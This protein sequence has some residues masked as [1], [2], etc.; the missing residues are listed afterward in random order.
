MNLKFE[1]F[2]FSDKRQQRFVKHESLKCKIIKNTN[3]RQELTTVNDQ[4][5]P[6][7]S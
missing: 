1:L 7:R 3:K 4:L 6:T 2:K 5:D